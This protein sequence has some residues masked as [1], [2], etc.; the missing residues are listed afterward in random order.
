MKTDKVVTET[1]GD[2]IKSY[3]PFWIGQL[4]SLFGSQIVSFVIGV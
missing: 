1:S 4:F 2:S 3:L